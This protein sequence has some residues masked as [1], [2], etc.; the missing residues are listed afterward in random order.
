MPRLRLP[1]SGIPSKPYI[2]IGSKIIFVTAPSICAIVEYNER[3]VACSIF[4]NIEKN[5]IP[6]DK[7]QHIFKYCIAI[8]FINS[9]LVCVD[10]L[11]ICSKYS[12]NK[13]Y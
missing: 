12:E 2:K 8:F 6:I 4:S 9:L 13:K 7:V 10:T 1:I 5:T 3:P 11:E